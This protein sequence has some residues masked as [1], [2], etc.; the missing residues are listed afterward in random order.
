MVACT[1]QGFGSAGGFLL[2]KG[3][4]MLAQYDGYMDIFFIGMYVWLN[5]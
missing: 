4:Y 1:E 5:W 3:C 2:L